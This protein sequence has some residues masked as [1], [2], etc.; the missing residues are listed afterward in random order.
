MP[1]QRRDDHVEGILGF[2]AVCLWVHQWPNCVQKFYD[3]PRPTVRQDDWQRARVTGSNVQKM[4]AE[5]IDRRAK[6]R[7]LIDPFLK[8]APIVIVLPP[9]EKLLHKIKRST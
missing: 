3:R 1:G 2:T 4:D 8:S 5:P 6:L 7:K 9:R